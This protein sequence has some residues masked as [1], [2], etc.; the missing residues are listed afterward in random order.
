VRILVTGASGL[1]GTEVVA[2]LVREG[3]TVITLTH[4]EPRL[5]RNSGRAEIGTVPFGSGEGPVERL[6]GDVSRPRLGLDP[7]TARKLQAGV[8]RIVHSAATTDFGLPDERY[9]TVNVEGTR[10]VLA[11]AAEARTP[12]VHVST[13]YVC[14]EREGRCAESELD[15]GQRFANPY[16]RTKFEAELLV[17]GHAQEGHPVVTVRPSVVVGA[18]RTG[19][20]RDFKNIYVMVKLIAEGRLRILPGNYGATPNLVPVD[21]VAAVVAEAAGERF[22]EA[23]GRVLHAV[24]GRSVSLRELSDVMAEYPSFE[25]ARFVP[26]AS[27]SV[28]ALDRR[29]QLYYKRVG[30]LYESYLRRRVEFDDANARAF[31]GRRP[32]S[33]GKATL[34]KLFDHCLDSRYIDPPVPDREASR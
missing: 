27:F 24:G 23:E 4:R 32:P 21:Y 16:E 34:R 31:M 7:E 17:A 15:M 3:H 26:P 29:G 9:E 30:V 19:V 33:T 28:S 2:A 6:S 20:V 18:E 22:A 8:D 14:G 1:V 12:L 5:V 13:A 11:M 25:V 10:N